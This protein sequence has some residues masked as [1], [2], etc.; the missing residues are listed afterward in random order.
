MKITKSDI[1]YE[2]VLELTESKAKF[3]SIRIKK[4]TGLAAGTV[5]G[6]LFQYVAKGWVKKVN[7]G[8]QDGVYLMLDRVAMIKRYSRPLYQ[9]IDDVLDTHNFRGPLI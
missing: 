9:I 6:A 5:G 1:I 3:S 8:K 7:P 2:K 4:E